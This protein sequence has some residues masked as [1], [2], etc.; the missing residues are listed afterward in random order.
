[1]ARCP[2]RFAAVRTARQPCL[3]QGQSAFARCPLDTTQYSPS[4]AM[5]HHSPVLP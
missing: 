1:M 4:R 2:N 3:T 5:R